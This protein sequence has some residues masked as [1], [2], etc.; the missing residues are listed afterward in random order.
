MIFESDEDL[1]NHI[2]TNY[3][4]ET[5]LKFLDLVSYYEIKYCNNYVHGEDIERYANAKKIGI[6]DILARQYFQL[7]KQQLNKKM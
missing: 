4:E 1:W 2:E 6:L 3:D 5:R 7:V